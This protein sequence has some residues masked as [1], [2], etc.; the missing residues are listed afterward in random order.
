MFTCIPGVQE[1]MEESVLFFYNLGLRDRTQVVK[2][3]SK[4]L[5]QLSHLDNPVLIFVKAV[6]TH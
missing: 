6:L 2:V 1:F 5:H 3:G 4:P